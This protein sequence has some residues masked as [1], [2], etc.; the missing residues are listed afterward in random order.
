[1][2]PADDDLLGQPERLESAVMHARDNGDQSCAL[3][4]RYVDGGCSAHAEELRWWQANAPAGTAN[5]KASRAA[6]D[7]KD[8]LDYLEPT[9]DSAIA[10][11]LKSGGEKYGRGNYRKSDI[12]I[13]TYVGA[14]R[15]HVA[16]WHSGEDYDPD[17][18]LHHLA[19]IGA[20]VHVV[21]GA[22]DAGTLVDDRALAA[23]PDRYAG[24]PHE[25]CLCAGHNLPCRAICS[26]G[27]EPCID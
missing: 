19:H 23:P 17:T 26:W 6:S 21:L 20:S 8:P 24:C 16:A 25:S 3:I 5:P 15:R 22:M 1:M 14:I 11:A 18:G 9:A 4:L 12:L 7:A 13:T 10:R 2:T 27:R